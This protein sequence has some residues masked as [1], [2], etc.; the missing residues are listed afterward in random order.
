MK[1][2]EKENL[3]PYLEKQRA[4]KL[5]EMGSYLR[6]LREEQ[7]LS[8]DE[9]AAMTKVQARLLNA[10]EEGNLEPLPEPV[11]I[12]GFVKRYADALGLD[13]AEFASVLPTAQSFQFLKPS[14]R[15]LPSVPRLKAIH[16]YLVY[17]FLIIGAVNGL[18]GLVK[19]SAMQASNQEPEKKAIAS[20]SKPDNKPK[21]DSL[22]LLSSNSSSNNPKSDKPLRVG[23]TLKEE[24]WIRVVADGKTRFEGTLPEGTQRT[25]EAKEE[26][27]IR[28]GN[29]GGVLVTFNEKQA[30]PL[31]VSGKP[32]T[33]S[34]KAGPQS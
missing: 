9:V 6:H 13:G 19:N 25:W 12:Q 7:S 16:L 4:E 29:A 10:I 31:G 30:E 17:I 15:S 26:L 28:A 21:P 22:A 34:F 8:L 3:L 32:E 33:K 1:R 24:S 23:I 18:S 2:N 14:W 11:Y 5:A 20:P 27:I